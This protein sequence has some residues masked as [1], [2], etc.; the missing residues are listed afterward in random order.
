MFFVC[1]ELDYIKY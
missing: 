1:F